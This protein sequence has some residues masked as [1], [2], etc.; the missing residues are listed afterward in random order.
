MTEL[1][2]IFEK[3]A[4]EKRPPVDNATLDALQ[5][6]FSMPLPE[7]YTFFL[8]HYRFIAHFIG[9][10][11]VVLHEAEE[12]EAF[13]RDY[14]VQDRFPSILGIGSNGA[15]EMIGIHY[16]LAGVTRIV[17]VPYTS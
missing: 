14:R 10:E 4:I 7:D 8:T 3:Y 6:A 16:L 12:L 13:N 15:S 9:E 17:L 1:E 11:Y 5:A 2:S